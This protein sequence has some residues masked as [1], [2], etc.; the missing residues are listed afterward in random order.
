[1]H[2]YRAGTTHVDAVGQAREMRNCQDLT[3][4]MYAS[5]VYVVDL[6]VGHFTSPMDETDVD[7]T[8]VMFSRSSM[9]WDL[10][11]ICRG[12]LGLM[13]LHGDRNAVSRVL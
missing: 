7:T 5:R 13:N 4:G 9:T 2:E 11:T 6:W 3:V 12:D 8:H 10:S 1:M